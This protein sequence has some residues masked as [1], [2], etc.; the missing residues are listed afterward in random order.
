VPLPVAHGLIVERVKGPLA[1]AG[2]AALV[3]LAL[4]ALIAVY[5]MVVDD[6][7]EGIKD[8]GPGSAGQ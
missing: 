2:V 1:F 5:K 8:D 6:L 3:A 7:G 4:I